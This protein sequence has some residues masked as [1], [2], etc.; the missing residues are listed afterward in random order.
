MSTKMPCSSKDCSN[1]A[2]RYPK[3]N[4][5]AVGYKRGQGSPCMFFMPLAV[6]RD[7]S[8][9]FD[10]Q[11]FLLPEG[12]ARI[13]AAMAAMGKARPDFD[14]AWLTWGAIGDRDWLMYHQIEARGKTR[15]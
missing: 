15:Q 9:E 14:N 5:V 8:Q 6:C 12:R 7:C 11:N 1:N 3:I 2:G 4:M 13:A 10:V